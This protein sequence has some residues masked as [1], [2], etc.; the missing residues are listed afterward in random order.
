VTSTS[1]AALRPRAGPWPVRIVGVAGL[2]RERVLLP[3]G[4]GVDVDNVTV[5]GESVDERDDAGG[6]GE[7]GAPLFERE[8]RGD[9]RR[10][11]LV[12]TVD[13]GVEQVGGLAV[14]RQISNLDVRRARGGITA[15]QAAQ[16]RDRPG[17]FRY[18]RSMRD[19]SP[20]P[21][22]GPLDERATGCNRLPQPTD[23][24]AVGAG[25][26]EVSPV[27]LGMCDDPDT[28]SA[29]FD[30]GINFFFLTADMHWPVYERARVALMRLLERGGGVRDEI[31]VAGVSYVSQP[32]FC[33]AP[34]SELLAAV[35]ALDGRLDVLVAGGAYG[36][37]LERRWPVYERHREQRVL[38]AR[39]VGASFHDRALAA[40]L[41]CDARVD[42]GFIRYNAAHPGAQVDI[43]PHLGAG[44]APVFVFTSTR[45]HVSAAQA[46]AL[47]IDPDVWLPELVDTYRFALST[48]HIA[49]ILCAPQNPLEV[50]E[51]AAALARGPLDEDEREHMIALAAAARAGRLI[52]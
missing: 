27:C 37:E 32:E 15:R 10:S 8:V 34:F 12:P 11:L 49:G 18:A 38:G 16:E 41:L 48:P 2:A 23:R 51:L 4:V 5:L 9:D 1:A 21:G 22:S 26:V 45:G 30:L 24:I 52:T 35:P 36:W 28:F 47:G 40:T 7:H 3:P 33:V 39:A 46:A 25:G 31:V 50:R 13:Q 42:L 6:S 19:A 44:H 20:E 17:N 43:F 29:A 14:A